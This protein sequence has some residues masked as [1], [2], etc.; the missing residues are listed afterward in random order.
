VAL[1]AASGILS[2][3]PF[4]TNIITSMNLQLLFIQRQLGLMTCS[5]HQKSA[6]VK[7]NK[8]NDNLELEL[9]DA[10]CEKFEQEI[11]KKFDEFL[12]TNVYNLVDELSV[13]IKK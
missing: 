8:I 4:T 1:A 5:I 2:L 13:R 11:V 6:G 9:T 10:C 12:D 7:L 3:P